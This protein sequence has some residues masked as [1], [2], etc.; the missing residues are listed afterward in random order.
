MSVGKGK[1]R[2]FCARRGENLG[3]SERDDALAQTGN[4][5]LLKVFA[6]EERIVL[7]RFDNY[8]FPGCH[9]PRA[10]RKPGLR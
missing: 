9:D 5:C 8:H 2:E 7:P 4:Q 1:T 6:K 10:V 3:P